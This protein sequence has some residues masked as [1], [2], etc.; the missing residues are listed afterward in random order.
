MSNT[1]LE[2][3]RVSPRRA[4]YLFCFAKIS[5][6]QKAT[7][8]LPFGCLRF[9]SAQFVPRK[10][11]EMNETRCAQTTFISDPFSARHKLQSP[12]RKVKTNN[13]TTAGSPTLLRQSAQ[14]VVF[15]RL[16]ED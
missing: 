7:A 16:L 8:D 4:T 5:R 13:K 2:L 14:V 15:R 12:Q 6:Q 10:K 3:S 1:S 9:A 11:W